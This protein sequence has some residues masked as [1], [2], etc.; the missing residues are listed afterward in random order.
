M[1]HIDGKLRI[2]ESKKILYSTKTF[3]DTASSMIIEVE[4]EET[5]V[6]E[7]NRRIRDEIIEAQRKKNK[8]NVGAQLG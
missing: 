6:E 8:P 2:V 5:D 3:V 1:Y 4:R 7:N